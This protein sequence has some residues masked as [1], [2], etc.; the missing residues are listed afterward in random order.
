[1]VGVLGLPDERVDLVDCGVESRVQARECPVRFRHELDRF[2]VAD[3]FTGRRHGDKADPVDIAVDPPGSVVGADV[4]LV[5]VGQL[6][7]EV[8]GLGGDRVEQLDAQ[9][10]VQLLV[11]ELS[12]LA[13]QASLLDLAL[14]LQGV[15]AVDTAPFLCVF[16]LSDSGAD[17]P[18]RLLPQSDQV[19][20]DGVQWD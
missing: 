17:Q 5:G 2:V 16:N 1:M 3:E 20:A 12:L 7:T 19:V 13:G 10:C 8:L 18:L 15:L 6:T 11:L 4:E 9:V 14:G